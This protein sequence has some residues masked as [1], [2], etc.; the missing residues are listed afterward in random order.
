MI[1]SSD[2]APS[3]LG[4]YL[5]FGALLLVIVVHGLY[6]LIASS[7]INKAADNWILENERA[8]YVISHEGLRVGG[9]P[10]RFTIHIDAPDITAPQSDGGWNARLNRAAAS[11][12]FYALGH[13][14]ITLGET[15]E[16]ATTIDGAPARYSLSAESA[17]FSLRMRDGVTH[18]VGAE[19][20]NFSMEALEGA[21]PVI[22][23]MDTFLLSGR[24]DDDDRLATR[25]QAEGTV[26]NDT[27]LSTPLREAFGDTAQMIRLDAELSQFSALAQAGDPRA[28]TRAGGQIQINGAQLEW[29]PATLTGQGHITLDELSRPAGRLSVVVSDPESLVSA[30]EASGIVHED[31][32]AALRLAAM[33]APRRDQGIALPFRL[34]DGGLFLGPARIGSIQPL[35]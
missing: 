7:Q 21:A 30:L 6:W 25:I 34:Q 11:A 13:W 9:Y 19:V 15:G 32:G 35:D 27:V 22:V 29:G 18:D 26:F 31:Q 28:W 24:T 4:L 23:T 5:P 14:I 16:L 33:M 20:L 8:G 3:R 17:R 2:K 10:F 1:Q 12:Q